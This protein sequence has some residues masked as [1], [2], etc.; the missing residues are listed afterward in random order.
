M[1]VKVLRHP[2]AFR[3]SSPEEFVALIVVAML[4]S[5]TLVI[6]GSVEL[7]ERA[8]AFVL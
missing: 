6:S 5:M 8:I 4:T 1:K 2:G 3:N 7:V